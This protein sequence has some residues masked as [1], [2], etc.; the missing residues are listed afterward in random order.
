MSETPLSPA[1]RSALSELRWRIRAY[2]LADGLALAA[3]WIG[4]TFWLG[5]ALD[6]LPVLTWAS[7]M[8]QPVRAV[9]LVVVAGGLAWIVYQY[10]LR[11]VF[12]RMRDRS[13]ALLVERKFRGFSDELVT[14]VELSQAA[15]RDEAYDPEMLERTKRIAETQVRRLRLADIFNSKPLW[16]NSVLAIMLLAPVVPFAVLQPKA[17]KTWVQRFYML[18][19]VSWPRDTLLHVVG[20]QPQRTAGT[21]LATEGPTAVR[22]FG[23]DQAMKIAKG[24]SGTLRV[25]AKSR[26]GKTPPEYC[27]VYYRS[28]D[29]L[30]A[31]VRMNKFG[32]VT[33]DGYQLYT[34]AS[35][36]FKG[37]LETLDFDV[38]AND[39]RL[40]GYRLD[41][42]ESPQIGEVTLDCVF[43]E[44]LVDESSSSWLP[45]TM[46]YVASGTALPIGT[47]VTLNLLS[48]KPL[49]EASIRMGEEGE[50]QPA[51]LLDDGK[52][53][54][55]LPPLDAS[56]TMYVSVLDKDGVEMDRPQK[57]V[58]GAVKDN[59]PELDVMHRGISSMVTPDAI[60]PITGTVKDDYGVSR[61]WFE[62]MTPDGR[63]REFEDVQADK[64]GILSGG[65][66]LRSKRA[67]E[68]EK[69]AV[70]L[71]PG[72]KITVTAMAADRFDLGDAANV[73]VGVRMDLEVVTP[74]QLLTL[75]DQRELAQRR[76]FEHVIEEMRAMRDDVAR[77]RGDF[78]AG[79]EPE[80]ELGEEDN[81]EQL[82]RRATAL[83]LLRMQQ[84]GLQSEKSAQETAAVGAAFEDIVLELVNNRVDSEDRKERLT[85]RVIAPLQ[86][87]AETMFPELDNRLDR[88]QEAI[89]G[90]AEDRVEVAKAAV[91]QVDDVLAE[92][93]KV[94]AEM[95]YIETFNEIIEAIRIIKEEQAKIEQETEK[96]R[97]RGLKGLL[98]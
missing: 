82:K 43:P 72:T 73:G 76:M 18:K 67:L 51:K 40:G 90:E 10:I 75:L 20:L 97:A 92:M 88:L 27:T 44:Y 13:M 52:I 79:D 94:L 50:Q 93:D 64:D 78:E 24:S 22:K 41:V 63:V 4:L 9:G 47:K 49:E 2:V 74:D 1:I 87:I 26:S 33:N 42:V 89:G 19:E 6:Y 54:I 95:Q 15:E 91:E 35:K 37:V 96:E 25:K 53:Q 5:L 45:R 59:P 62:L 85:T 7:E 36:P 12:V 8:P 16:R 28:P 65:L 56:T 57:F 30:R 71:K 68:D 21:A 60:I 23:S 83:R 3:V 66:D 14:A 17:M 55:E 61:L 77:V 48:N 32:R 34:L 80:G 84:A 29:G 31:S 39:R 81:L 86:L 11:R 46:D 38:V 69:V 98:E 70:D 58:I